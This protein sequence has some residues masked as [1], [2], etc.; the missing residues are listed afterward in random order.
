M[1]RFLKYFGFITITLIIILISIPFFISLDSYKKIIINEVYKK[2]GRNLIIDGEIALSLFPYPQIELN[3]IKLS[4][5]PGSHEPY[6]IEAKQISASLTLKQLIARNFTVHELEVKHPKINLEI[7][8]NG[9]GNWEFDKS[10]QAKNDEALPIENIAI[11]HAEI[12]YI[13]NNYHLKFQADNSNISFDKKKPIIKS[14]ITFDK[15]NY[16]QLMNI[17]NNGKTS[18]AW[19]HD[20]IDLSHLELFDAKFNISIPNF[21]KSALYFDNISTKVSLKNG[22][23]NIDSLSGNLYGG[24]LELSGFISSKNKQTLKLKAKLSDAFLKNIVPEANKFKVTRGNFN[25]AADITTHGK[26]QL[27]LVSNL[28][29]NTKF[30]TGNGQLSGVDLQKALDALSNAKDLKSVLG[31]LN[32]SFSAGVTDFDHL[33][34]NFIINNGNANLSDF[35]LSAKRILATASGNINLPKYVMDINSKI[36]VD[37]KGFPPFYA[38]FHGPLNNPQHKLDT[39]ALKNYLIKNVLK[40]AINSF[41]NGVTA[42]EDIIKGLTGFGNK[43]KTTTPPKDNPASETNDDNPESKDDNGKVLQKGLEGILKNFNS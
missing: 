1:L 15:I 4:S 36:D 29:G 42:P 14:K 12:Q 23:L 8:K 5:I 28:S 20:L 33:D 35:K 43:P 25:L 9:K 39:G 21:T 11:D 37:L 34:G 10:L 38:H 32:N 31:L 40:S 18:T 13:K 3:Q 16:D 24:K 17:Q 22:T 2:T 30:D 41:A 19:S 27:Q 7:L 6:L 26:N